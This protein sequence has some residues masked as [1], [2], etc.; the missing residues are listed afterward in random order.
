M[1][2]AHNGPDYEGDWAWTPPAGSRFP[3]EPIDTCAVRELAEETGLSGA[4]RAVRGCDPDWALFQLDCEA[5]PDVSLDAEHDR[6]EWV[7]LSEAR[8]RCRPQVIVAG[9]DLAVRNHQ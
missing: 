4:L 3:G 8:L 5:Q 9:L 1:H 6:Y 2:R 7:T